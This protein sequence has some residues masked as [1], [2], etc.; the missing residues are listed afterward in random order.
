MKN[1]MFCCF[2]ADVQRPCVP[3][4]IGH[5]TRT[6]TLGKHD[7]ILDFFII[8]FPRVCVAFWFWRSGWLSARLDWFGISVV[9]RIRHS[10]SNT[11]FAW[12]YV[13]PTLILYLKNKIVDGSV[14]GSN[15][16]L[17]TMPDTK[18]DTQ[19]DIKCDTNFGVDTNDIN[20][21]KRFL[22][23]PGHISAWH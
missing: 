17:D 19:H 14:S 12:H 16:L 2:K 20:L 6:K 9:F 4:A 5:S 10:R 21:E 1:W 11:K 22:L 15:T 13:V 23:R 3:G 7:K 8:I 18:R